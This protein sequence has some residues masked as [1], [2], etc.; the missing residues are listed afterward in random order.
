MWCESRVVTRARKIVRRSEIRI[1]KRLV[2]RALVWKA[3]LPI[4]SHRDV[5]SKEDIEWF[6]ARGIVEKQL[7]GAR[8]VMRLV[9]GDIVLLVRELQE[10]HHLDAFSF[11]IHDHVGGVPT[12]FRKRAYI[13]LTLYFAK[14][15]GVR[16]L[17]SSAWKFVGPG[18]MT[19][20]VAGID[21]ALFI[22]KKVQ[23]GIDLINAQCEWYLQ[24]VESFGPEA[25]DMDVLKQ[26]GQYL[27][28]F[29]NMS[30]LRVS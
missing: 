4:V 19:E 23:T 2:D 6:A 30:Q 5:I 24:L 1:P 3:Y 28:F 29:A 17:F 18:G 16:K 21:S 26:V 11:L 20:E 22:E 7:R 27:H 15:V 12:R 25:S 9:R 14:K 10:K 13:D 8:A